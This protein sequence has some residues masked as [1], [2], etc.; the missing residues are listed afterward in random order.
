MV[1]RCISWV[2]H[3][4]IRH[5]PMFF[6]Q[7]PRIELAV[8]N[9]AKGPPQC[10][11]PGTPLR[12]PE[13]GRT[14]V[15][16]VF[17]TPKNY[18]TVQDYNCF[19]R[20]LGLNI[21]NQHMSSHQHPLHVSSCYCYYGYRF[22]GALSLSRVLWKSAYSRSNMK[23]KSIPKQARKW[24]EELFCWFQVLLHFPSCSFHLHAYSFH[25]TFISSILYSPF[26]F[27]SF[28]FSSLH[29]PFIFLSFSFQCAL[30]FLSFSFQCAFMSFHLPFICMNVPFILHSCP[31]FLSKVMEMALWLGQ[32]TECNKWLS[33]SYR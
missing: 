20:I 7:T 13:P 32:G 9:S 30:I 18:C 33:L 12:S 2:F 8:F 1:S 6:P 21:L 10:R 3:F 11:R 25:S 14:P 17:R 24:I 4:T 23:P 15:L 27:L 16:D 31:L 22:W 19:T 28:V 5:I 29:F 26:M